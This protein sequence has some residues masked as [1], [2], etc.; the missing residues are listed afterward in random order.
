VIYNFDSE[1]NFDYM[2]AVEVGG[3]SALPKGLSNLQVPGRKYAVFCHRGHIA[4]IR[5]TM[6]AIWSQWLPQSGYKAFEGP[7]LERYGPEFNP[8]TGMGGLEIWVP[9][10]E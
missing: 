1:G 5:G 4:G 9:I 8:M 6:S 3:A 10:Q 2:C 7:T